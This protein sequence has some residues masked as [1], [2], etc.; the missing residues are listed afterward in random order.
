M[1]AHHGTLEAHPKVVEAH[2][3]AIET[4]LGEGEVHQMH[5]VI[6]TRLTA[7]KNHLRLV[8]LLRLTMAHTEA[9]EAFVGSMEPWNFIISCRGFYGAMES[10]LGQ[11]RLILE[12]L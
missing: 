8:E 11:G 7:M 6:K 10:H 4:H 5:V 1:G 9:L 2:P 12:G 3:R